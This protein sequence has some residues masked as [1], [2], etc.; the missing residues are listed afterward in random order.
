MITEI[1][2]ALR[3]LR[4]DQDERLLDMAKRLDKS[5]AFLSAVE[6]G[7]KSPPP[8]LEDAVVAAY[9][10]SGAAVD[11]ICRAAN[12]SRKAFKLEPESELGRDTAGLLA[13]K[14]NT[15]NDS[16]LKRIMDILNNSAEGK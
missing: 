15:L 10:L 5:S 2:K 6:I 7:K 14:M 4:I 8:G 13:R 12:Q 9:R 16:E 11:L 3:K 1:G